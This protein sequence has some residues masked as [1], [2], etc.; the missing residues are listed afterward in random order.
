MAG[1]YYREWE[2]WIL[3]RKGSE[4]SRECIVGALC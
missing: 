3:S 1:W 4:V 2:A